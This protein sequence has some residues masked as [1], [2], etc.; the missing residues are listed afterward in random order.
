MGYCRT[1]KPGLYGAGCSH[2]GT[3]EHASM[4]VAAR[5]GMGRLAR[6]YRSPRHLASGARGFDRP[7]H[8]RRYRGRRIPRRRGFCSAVSC[9]ANSAVGSHLRS[10]A[11]ESRSVR[12]SA[13]S[14]TPT[15]GRGANPRST[16]GPPPR[17]HDAGAGAGE[18]GTAVGGGSMLSDGAG[19]D[20]AGSG[21][22]RVEAG[23]GAGGAGAGGGEGSPS[24]G[25]M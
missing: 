25:S 5:G 1:E 3:P 6:A 8:G 11:S 4:H 15:N 17:R 19:T 9:A 12:Y 13:S 14:F 24:I 20:C 21:A 2:A 23:V 16:H 7:A 10:N 18:G 22:G